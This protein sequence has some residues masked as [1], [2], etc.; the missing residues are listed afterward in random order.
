MRNDPTH[1]TKTRLFSGPLSASI[2]HTCF[3]GNKISPFR[4]CALAYLAHTSPLRG[5]AHASH[6]TSSACSLHT[7]RANAPTSSAHCQPLSPKQLQ[8]F[9]RADAPCPPPTRATPANC[10]T[11]NPEHPPPPANCWPTNLKQ[12]SCCCC[13][14]CCCS[15]AEDAHHAPDLL[16]SPNDGVQASCIGCEVS[17]VLGQRLKVGIATGTVNL[18]VLS[19]AGEAKG[20]TAQVQQWRQ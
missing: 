16:I 9:L 14:C 4:M 1:L 7:A 2:M 20:T 11:L 5:C 12:N 3:T 17:A 13:C 15:P 18:L 10:R 8:L 19:G 6:T